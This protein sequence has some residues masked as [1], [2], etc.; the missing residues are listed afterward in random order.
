M[1]D[2][3]N[4]FIGKFKNKT[5]KLTDSYYDGPEEEIDINWKK[6]CEKLQK[7]NDELKLSFREQCIN[8]FKTRRSIRKFRADQK[9]DFKVIFDIIE[10]GL[11]APVAG[12]LQNFRVIVVE[13][14]VQKREIG[15]LAYQQYWL[16]EAPY[17]LVIIRDDVYVSEMYPD[18]GELFSIQNTAALIENILMATHMSDL[19][20][21]WVGVDDNNAIKD[22]L[23][24]PGGRHI[25]AVIPIGYPMES[26]QVDKNPTQALVDFK[27]FGDKVR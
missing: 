12:N 22:L 17:V 26:P 3:L 18:K 23:G 10:A 6:E 8:S 21:C 27:K 11:N 15:K 14:E 5:I 25:D 16:S 4:E 13:D 19:G 24:V 1:K 2:K 7:E 9:P 20:A